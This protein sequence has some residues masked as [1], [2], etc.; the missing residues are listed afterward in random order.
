MRDFSKLFCRKIISLLKK[1]VAD[2]SSI[3]NRLFLEVDS[4]SQRS[5]LKLNNFHL[6]KAIRE[7]EEHVM[8]N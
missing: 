3:K 2:R 6:V 7:G 4:L 8:R 1:L 5:I